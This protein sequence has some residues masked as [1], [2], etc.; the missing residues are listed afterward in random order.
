MMKVLVAG[1]TGVL[2]KE[3]VRRL[4]E[5][6]H[7]VTALV[8]STSAPQKVSYLEG[9]GASI[10]QGDL[11]DPAS[12][13]AACREVDAVIST[14]S[15]ILTA[16]P[17]DSFAATDGAGTRNLIDAA[18]AAHARHFVFVSFDTSVVPDC[19]LVI[20]KREA[21]DHLTQSGLTYSILHP[22]LFMESWL[23]P[24]LFADPNAGTARIYGDGQIRIR[25]VAMTNVAELA[26]RCLTVPSAR[27]AIIPFGGP[28]E[29]SQRE[30]LR[31]FEEAYE[32]SFTVTE[33]PEAALEAAW[34]SADDP[35]Q[36]SF[37]ALMLSVARGLDRRMRPPFDNFPM[38]MVSVA[39]FARTNAA[40]HK[41]GM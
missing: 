15:M 2:G 28:E 10:V 23:G 41:M 17:G 35:L 31:L 16:Q 14:V 36:K 24:M 38:Q 5:E 34:R 11:K 32:Q 37:S 26:V 30:A 39:D 1:A 25:Y 29:L 3:I 12:L 20:T 33:L 13:A 22:S 8:R 18:V 21:E 4:R 19:P 6:R 9:L 27:N 7:A 40:A